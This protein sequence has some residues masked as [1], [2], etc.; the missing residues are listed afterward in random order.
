[1]AVV[2]FSPSGMLSFAGAAKLTVLG[3][4]M[5]SSRWL[6]PLFAGLV[7]TGSLP[8]QTTVHVSALGQAGWFADD[9]R[10]ANGTDLV[11]A[12]YT[13]FGKPGQ[14][15]TAADDLALA[16]R[17]YF[18]SDATSD[19]GRGG[20]TFVLDSAPGKASKST[21]ALSRDGGFGAATQLTAG[22]FSATYD[23][24]QDPASG[25]TRMVFRFGLQT[26]HYHAGSGGSQNGFTAIRTGESE[27]DVILVYVPPASTAGVWNTTAITPDTVGWKVFFQAGNSFWSDHYGLASSFGPWRSL[28]EWAAF[29][30]DPDTAGVQSFLDGATISSIQFGLGS[31]TSSA[32]ESTLASFSTSLLSENYVFAAIPEPSTYVLLAGL[33]VLGAAWLRRRR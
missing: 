24:L 7:V 4:R 31:S 30:Y 28:N 9:S 13:L 26:S 17:M 6:F 19:Y 1:M 22:G 11:G 16:G 33:A 18:T 32:G 12:A 27:W 21:L 15:A 29:D 14:T 25:S 5:R 3:R 20:L 10:D 23:W 8:A 2:F